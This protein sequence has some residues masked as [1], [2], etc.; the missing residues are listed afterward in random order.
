MDAAR[1]RAACIAAGLTVAL[2]LASV[3]WDGA[4]PL[5]QRL[6]HVLSNGEKSV[7]LMSTAEQ[8]KALR[9]RLAHTTAELQGYDGTQNDSSPDADAALETRGE[10]RRLSARSVQDSVPAP[11]KRG[12]LMRLAARSVRDSAPPPSHL[13][14]APVRVVVEDGGE[15]ILPVEQQTG[16]AVQL[17]QPLPG[18]PLG[19]DRPVEAAA[20]S[21]T[22][23]PRLTPYQ[24]SMLQALNRD[25]ASSDPQAPAV[26]N[27]VGGMA[28]KGQQLG[29]MDGQD[30]RAVEEVEKVSD[31]SN[32]VLPARGL[33][34][35]GIHRV[36]YRGTSLIRNTPV[37]G[38]YRGPMPRDL[39]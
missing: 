39:W 25:Y 34:A 10:L 27:M 30:R 28:G 6:G 13:A 36:C 15:E 8:L 38:P 31:N 3:G 22:R 17:V 14:P 23:R 21:S 37:V 5:G 2:L 20:P 4:R 12:A 29:E 19:G 33:R 18:Q 24:R 9:A 16:P 11:R 32:Q 1:R 35:S 7:S 26:A